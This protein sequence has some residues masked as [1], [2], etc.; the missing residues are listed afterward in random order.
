MNLFCYV[1]ILLLLFRLHSAY[2]NQV[3]IWAKSRVGE[4]SVLCFLEKYSM[5]YRTY[6][7]LNILSFYYNP[8]GT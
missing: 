1:S 5:Q 3:I 4:N 8:T 6:S 2:P 7:N